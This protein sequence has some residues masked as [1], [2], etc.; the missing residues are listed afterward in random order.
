MKSQSRPGGSRWRLAAVEKH[1]LLEHRHNG[2]HSPSN[3][4]GEIVAND[5]AVQ[6]A[7]PT[8][9]VGLISDDRSTAIQSFQ[10]VEPIVNDSNESGNSHQIQNNHTKSGS[11]IQ[12]AVNVKPESEPTRARVRIRKKR[13]YPNFSIEIAKKPRIV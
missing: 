1:I 6:I 7:Q 3:T 13:I 8:T 12:S 2:N 10:N 9:N 5:Q 4:S 11:V